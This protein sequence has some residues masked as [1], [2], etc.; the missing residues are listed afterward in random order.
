MPLLENW[1]I[2]SL[3]IIL[4]HTHDLEERYEMFVIMPVDTSQK[5][6]F[7]GEGL[8]EA[9]NIFVGNLMGILPA[10]WRVLNS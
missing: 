10:E 9:L 4:R 8:M 6:T 5:L 1:L 3:L 2:K 7:Y